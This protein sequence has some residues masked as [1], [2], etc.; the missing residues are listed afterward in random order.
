MPPDTPDHLPN[1]RTALHS[2][3][4]IAHQAVTGSSLD[5]VLQAVT[6]GLTDELHAAL[7]RIWLLQ[8][9]SKCPICSVKQ[10]APDSLSLHLA[11][12]SGL[13][14][15]IDCEHH[16]IPFGNHPMAVVARDRTPLLMDDLDTRPDAPE[17]CWI[18]WP[19]IR[20]M[21]VYPLVFRGKALGIVAVLST[22]ALSEYEFDTLRAFAAQATIT[23]QNAFLLDE[24]EAARADLQKL[25]DERTADLRRKAAEAEDRARELTALNNV[26]GALSRS[27]DSYEIA[28]NVVQTLICSTGI[29][30]ASIHLKARTHPRLAACG[31]KTAEGGFEWS[32]SAPLSPPPDCCVV[33][34][35]ESGEEII[36]RDASDA[37]L[38]KSI[39]CALGSPVN[40]AMCLPIDSRETRLGVLTVAGT[41]PR[42][43]NN[44]DMDLVRAIA[45]Q[46]GLALENANLLESAQERTEMLSLA[47]Q[48]THHR[49]KNNLQAISSLLE[50]QQMQPGDLREGLRRVRNQVRA[51]ALVHDYLSQDADLR[52]VNV[53]PVL[54]ALAPMVIS[55]HTR[56]DQDIR[57]S[58]DA[59]PL[60]IPSREATSLALIVSELVAN[61]V[62]H[63]L[64]DRDRGTITLSVHRVGGTLT[65]E[66]SDDGKGIP[67]G[68]HVDRDG[69]LGTELVQRLV[70]RHLKGSVE[71]IRD[72]GTRVR[73]TVPEVGF[74]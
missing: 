65:L 61:A 49:V 58:I 53:R 36:L 6:S 39:G 10:G 30:V 57:L 45:H 13:S 15:G 52:G 24:A 9:D 16:R 2:I 47:I 1:E 31:R 50:M 68:F 21:A 40:S 12:S 54:E 20:S 25:V 41:K 44:R 3:D 23:I 7:A 43:I 32:D 37:A 42:A 34:V 48:E 26:T 62:V 69:N 11:A 67:E 60:S 8:P 27:S 51:I 19:G 56:L 33:R 74:L 64:N 59:E 5:D 22:R 72:A 28:R 14:L 66:V 38:C 35:M 71:F 70:R 55:S 29:E 18:E 4:R 73:V 63:G 17:T 46:I